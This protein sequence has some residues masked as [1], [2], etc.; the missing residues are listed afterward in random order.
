M[1]LCNTFKYQLKVDGRIVY[2]GFTTDLQRREQ[3]HRVR[4]PRARIEQIGEP[5]SH[6]EAWE[7]ER[8]VNRP[9]MVAG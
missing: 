6:Q 5:T 1:A 9:S 2:Y 8:Q 3:E 4:W 7:W